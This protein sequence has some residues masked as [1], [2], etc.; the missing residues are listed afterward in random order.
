MERSHGRAR[1]SG[2]RVTVNLQADQGGPILTK[3][4][5]VRPRSSVRRFGALPSWRPVSAWNRHAET[6][7]LLP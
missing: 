4:Y 3:P 1:N 7:E 2:V 5:A 6:I